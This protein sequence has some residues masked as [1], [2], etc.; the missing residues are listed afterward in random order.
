MIFCR[1]CLSDGKA[2]RQQTLPCI[3]Q[4]PDLSNRL[5]ILICTA[6]I[7]ARNLPHCQSHGCHEYKCCTS[8][9]AHFPSEK[10]CHSRT[11]THFHIYC[12]V[13]HKVILPSNL[14]CLYFTVYTGRYFLIRHFYQLRQRICPLGPIFYRCPMNVSAIRS[15]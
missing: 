13:Y 5:C 11:C 1:I 12:T 14:S 3:D 8:G 9:Q 15:R 4:V 7:P 6:T 2:Y 10:S